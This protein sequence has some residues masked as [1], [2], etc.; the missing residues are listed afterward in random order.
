MSQCARDFDRPGRNYY[1]I[2][3][4]M[5][6]STM[7]LSIRQSPSNAVTALKRSIAALD[8]TGIESMAQMTGELMQSGDQNASITSP[9]KNTSS[10]LANAISIQSPQSLH[11]PPLSPTLPRMSSRLD[12]DAL[13]CYAELHV[14]PAHVPNMS[15]DGC[16]KSHSR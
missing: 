7:N 5:R 16:C 6:T 15:K 8:N 3:P 13:T 9:T 12:G 10:Q 2:I 1:M 14:A 4:R 11:S